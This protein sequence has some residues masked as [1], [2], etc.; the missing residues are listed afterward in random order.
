MVCVSN[1]SRIPQLLIDMQRQLLDIQAKQQVMEEKQTQM[2]GR[3]EKLSE[4]GA[5]TSTDS[6]DKG[7]DRRRLKERLKKASQRGFE[8]KHHVGW[9]EYIFGICSGD[10]RMGTE[11]SRWDN[12]PLAFVLSSFSCP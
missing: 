12:P 3:L 5:S 7:R 9:A 4:S 6:S 11:G 8:R 10:Q 1:T 2:D